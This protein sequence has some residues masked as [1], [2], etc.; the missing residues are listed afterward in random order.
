M[1]FFKKIGQVCR[2]HYE[3]IILT[4]ALLALGGTVFYLYGAQQ[5]EQ[6]NIDEY[7]KSV[8]NKPEKRIKVPDLAPLQA[9]LKASENPAS[10]V[11]SGPHNLL[12]PVKWQKKPDGGLIKVVSGEE[13]GGGAMV[14][15]KF[16]PILLTL[17]YDKVA[18][19]GYYFFVENQGATNAFFRRKEQRFATLNSQNKI[20]GSPAAF[21]LREVKG[22]PEDPAEL[23][24]ELTDTLE[25]VSIGKDKPYTRIEGYGVDLKYPPE[26]LT[27]L[28]QRVGS[29]LRF[30]GDTYT[31]V[32]V[33]KDEV[34]L[35]GSNDKRY[36]VR[37]AK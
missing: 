6:K 37:L 19:S 21:V 11:F 10:L 8:Q 32:A 25:R 31:I 23:V 18:G 30:A 2:L 16:T 7:L 1:D 22:P 26:N 35:S 12:N 28:A 33:T 14:A 4:V 36:Q 29:T 13:V 3:K 27:F 9:T 15:L 24:I 20:P 34:V 17:S 5:A